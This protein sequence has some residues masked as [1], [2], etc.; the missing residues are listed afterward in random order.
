MAEL[1]F[2]E[3][4]HLYFIDSK[5]VPS[6]TDIC[7]LLTA[8]GRAKLNPYVI[9]AAARRGTLVHEFTELLDYGVEPEDMEMPLDIAP[10]IL[11][12]Q[13]FLRD[14]KPQWTAIEKQVFDEQIGLAGTLDRKGILEG[15]PCILDIKTSSA[16]TRELKI[17]WVTQLSGYRLLQKN[18][19]L[20]RYILQL[21]GNGTYR[22][23]NARDLE[24][25]YRFDG[26][27]L[28]RQCLEIHRILKG[29]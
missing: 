22:L 14:Y 3:K 16:P 15:Y 27:R 18:A 21:R 4:G 17:A 5:P 11:A 20:E 8:Q 10:Y 29:D 7:S 6:V 2:V 23:F 13:R 26:L 9:D 28:F 19:A 12:Y 24:Q 1:K 25:Q